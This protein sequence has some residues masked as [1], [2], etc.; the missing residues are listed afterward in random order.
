MR[1]FV[2]VVGGRVSPVKSAR[3]RFCFDRHTRIHGLVS[4]RPIRIDSSSPLVA[5]WVERVPKKTKLDAKDRSILIALKNDARLAASA[6]ARMVGLSEGAVRGRIDKLRTRGD[7]RGFCTLVRPGLIERAPLVWV[8]FSI[9]VP[10]S[11]ARSRFEQ[12]LRASIC[13]EHLDRMRTPDTY[14]LRAY[15]EDVADLISTAALSAGIMVRTVAV[16]R[17]D[18]QIGPMAPHDPP[19]QK[20]RPPR[21]GTPDQSGYETRS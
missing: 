19:L 13:V 15:H 16:E 4:R 1:A 3:R 9:V 8:R 10:D 17:V 7:I 2:V 18:V 20:R 5:L 11:G 12:A 6:L 14:G 21:P